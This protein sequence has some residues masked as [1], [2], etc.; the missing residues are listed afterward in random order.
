MIRQA[1]SGD[2]VTP[3]LCPFRCPLGP[4]LG[5]LS[6]ADSGIARGQE[7]QIVRPA[8][9]L[10]VFLPG[11]ATSWMRFGSRGS[12]VQIRPPRLDILSDPWR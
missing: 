8:W 1:S 2:S 10:H 4:L 5:P 7:R 6:P 3:Q 11:F 12:A 9:G